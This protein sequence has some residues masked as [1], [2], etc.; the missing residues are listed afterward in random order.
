MWWIYS[1]S[2]HKTERTSTK[3]LLENWKTVKHESDGD[4]NCNRLSCYSHERIGKMTRGIGNKK[5]SVDHPDYSVVEIG[6]NTEKST[7]DLM[8]LVVTQTPVK[9]HLLILMWKTSRSNIIIII[10][11][12]IWTFFDRFLCIY[13]ND[14]WPQTILYEIELSSG[15]YQR[16]TSWT[17]KIYNVHDFYKIPFHTGRVQQSAKL[18]TGLKLCL[19]DNL[20]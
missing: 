11:I 3:T 17:T 10:I 9:Y 13:S 18:F 16:L 2:Q 14:G 8:R 7:A 5:A 20:K 4:T 1:W 6:Q 15:T 12:I 19:L